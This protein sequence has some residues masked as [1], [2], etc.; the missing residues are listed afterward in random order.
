[1]TDAFGGLLRHDHIREMGSIAA[2]KRWRGARWLSILG[3]LAPSM[4]LP[5]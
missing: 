5:M 4:S 2:P 3:I 1:M